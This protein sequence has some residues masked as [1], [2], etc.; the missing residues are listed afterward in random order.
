MWHG[1]CI[2]E[3]LEMVEK[4]GDVGRSRVVGC[5]VTGGEDDTIA[6][7]SVG[8]EDEG[9]LTSDVDREEHG[10]GYGRQA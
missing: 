7:A 8:G 5:E 6:A 3:G 9:E 10:R 1:P 4:S 2:S